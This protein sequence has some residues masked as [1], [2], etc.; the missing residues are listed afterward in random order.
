MM[1]LKDFL[2]ITVRTR[3]VA[4]LTDWKTG[5]MHDV[6]SMRPSALRGQRPFYAAVAYLSTRLTAFLHKVP[7]PHGR[8]RS[9]VARGQRPLH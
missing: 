9:P 2:S 5:F 7:S 8:G 6:I 1:F 3:L 4:A